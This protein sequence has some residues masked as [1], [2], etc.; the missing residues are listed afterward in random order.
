MTSILVALG[1][2]GLDI[3]T[4]L[5]SA[6]KT[7]SIKSNKLRDGIFKK[8]GFIILYALAY[9]IDH[10]KKF[11]GLEIPFN[12]LTFIVLYVCVTEI[13]S[14][15]ENLMKINEKIVPTKIVSFFKEIEVNTEN[16]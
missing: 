8:F 6:L 11:I 3:L 7:R 12:M 2:N 4:G 13:V 5:I 15:L 14:I 16:E 1:F 9:M 10:Y